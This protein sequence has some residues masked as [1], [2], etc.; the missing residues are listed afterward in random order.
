L[1]LLR[2]FILIVE[3]YSF[4]IGELPQLV[5]RLRIDLRG[6]GSSDDFSYRVRI[7]ALG[8][9]NEYFG[10]ITGGSEVRASAALDFAV[11]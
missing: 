7:T 3:K 2:K 9:V 4:N 1:D 10:S 5:Y 8:F 11:T 6:L